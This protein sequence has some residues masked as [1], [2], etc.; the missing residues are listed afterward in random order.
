MTDRT[1]H[2]VLAIGSVQGIGP[3]A[4]RSSTRA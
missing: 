4:I 2:I 1:E 3:E